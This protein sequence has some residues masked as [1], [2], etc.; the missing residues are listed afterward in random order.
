MKH[1]HICIFKQCTHA[2][3][4]V[5]TYCKFLDTGF[6]LWTITL[7]LLFEAIQHLAFTV[8]K[9]FV[10]NIMFMIVI[11]LQTL[12]SESLEVWNGKPEQ[13]LSTK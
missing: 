13:H 4:A 6:S 2:W 12:H 5:Q 10:L 9:V 8:T 11:N 3:R 7:G 1:T